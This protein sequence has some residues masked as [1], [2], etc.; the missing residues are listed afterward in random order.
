[1]GS[2]AQRPWFGSLQQTEE[3]Q[4]TE[5]ASTPATSDTSV[6]ATLKRNGNGWE[7]MEVVHN[8]RILSGICPNNQCCLNFQGQNKGA[9]DMNRAKT[10]MK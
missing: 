8:I 6:A 4:Q 1:M 5:S 9:P 2:R 10:H 3:R 7:A